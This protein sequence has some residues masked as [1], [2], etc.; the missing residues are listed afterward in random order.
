MLLAMLCVEFFS[1]AASSDPEMMNCKKE[2]WWVGRDGRSSRERG[3]EEDHLL[4]WRSDC[5]KA[6]H[7]FNHFPCPF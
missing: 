6:V 4:M 2:R 5:E 3:R 7:P 1:A